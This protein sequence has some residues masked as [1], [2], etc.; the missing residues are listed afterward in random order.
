MNSIEIEKYLGVAIQ[1]VGIL[2]YPYMAY[3]FFFKSMNTLG[4][5]IW[6]LSAASLHTLGMYISEKST[7]KKLER[8]LANGN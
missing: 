3:E 8:R 1:L 4:L 6:Y 5:I 7:R 2:Q